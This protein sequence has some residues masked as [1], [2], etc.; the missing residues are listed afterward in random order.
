MK[1]PNEKWDF[2]ASGFSDVHGFDTSDMEMFRKDPIA[3]LARETVQ[4][5]ID[6]KNHKA[7]EPIIVEF[8]TTT[9]PVS[10]IPGV[11][12]IKSQLVLC[13]KK[14]AGNT[15]ILE[16]IKRMREILDGNQVQVLRI[17][18]H[19]TVGLTDIAS[20]DPAGRWVSLLKNSGNSYKKEGMLGSKGIG[21]FA[22]FV[23]SQLQMVFYSSLNIDGEAG[24][25]GIC[26]LCAA[27]IPDS[28]DYTQGPGYYS[29]D[30]KHNAILRQ[31]DA[32]WAFH[33]PEGDSGTDLYI[34]GFAGQDGW[35][36]EV[37]SN[38]L[39][40]FVI[41]VAKNELV[42]KI[43]GTK[44]DSANLAKIIT[45][46]NWITQERKNSILSQY[47]CLSGGDSVRV[48][49]V[50]LEDFPDQAILYIKKYVP[51]SE[52]EKHATKK[53]VLA[54]YPFMRIKEY[55]DVS[56]IPCSALCLL[57]DGPLAHTLRDIENPQHS[58]W[59]P[60]RIEDPAKR[61]YVEG[62]IKELKKKVLDLIK[63]FLGKSGTAVTDFG[64]AGEFLPDIADAEGINKSIKDQS[65]E[66]SLS[67]EKEA[68]IS[69]TEGYDPFSTPDTIQPDIGGVNEEEQGDVS[70]PGGNNDN[71]GGEPHPG[72]EEGA[73]TE[74]DNVIFTKTHLSGIRS[75]LISAGPKNSGKYC[76]FAVAPTDDQQCS[77]AL[78]SFDDSGSRERPT[79][80]KCIL[81]G[82][83]LPVKE[84]VVSGFSFKKGEKY[85]FMLD[86][87]TNEYISGKVEF[88]A[89][90]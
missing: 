7:G 11:E 51:G 80:K 70:Y 9:I 34:I 29:P 45:D 88:Y 1:Q 32:P 87:E 12:D 31:C 24:F 47:D 18:D 35:Q 26:R 25:E 48:S 27:K 2:P 21:K 68:N 69:T 22:S 86:V 73:K 62:V 40:S 59:E 8:V 67:K 19:N 37:V 38:I 55:K 76:V 61:K 56:I 53:C 3:A 50:P 78:F 44:I 65:D 75:R 6:A 42:I 52:E 72:E 74:G 13:E 5:S 58:D 16:R 79:I 57:T 43:E 46:E 84:N 64:G 30:S 81:N 14:M 66:Q 90:R 71:P 15:K 39:E 63:D 85:R 83:E 54:R 4:N 17:S 10:Q 89:S 36:R 23:C 49:S 41:A 77:M 28:E 60:K 20:A 82:Q 33:R